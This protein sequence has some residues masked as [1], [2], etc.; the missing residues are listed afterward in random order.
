METELEVVKSAGIWNLVPYA[1]LP[2]PFH[3]QLSFPISS[4][5][6]PLP[7]CPFPVLGFPP[8]SS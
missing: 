3:L 1:S 5:V 2:F 4:F 8:R 6:P 7:S